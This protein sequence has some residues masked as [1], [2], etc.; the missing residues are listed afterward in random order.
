M[1]RTLWGMIVLGVLAVALAVAVPGSDVAM[2]VLGGALVSW[3][4]FH[5][6][7]E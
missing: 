5:L 6:M 3:A 4:S 1:K 2:I 7:T